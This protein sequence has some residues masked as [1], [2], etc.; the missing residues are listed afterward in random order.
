M[1][2]LAIL[3]L[4]IVGLFKYNKSINLSAKSLEDTTSG[5]LEDTLINNAN[6]RQE[7]M[8]RIKEVKT[9]HGVEKLATSEDLL[10]EL[11]FH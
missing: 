1:I 7:R 10:K 6:K 9:Q 3:I 4:V 8:K 5:M 11:G 2:E